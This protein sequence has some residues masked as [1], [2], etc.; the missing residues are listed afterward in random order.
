[1]ALIDGKKIAQE[2]LET[3]QQRV[4]A[5]SFVP[6]F[7]DVVVGNDPVVLSYVK[8]KGK[9]AERV[10][11]EFMEVQLQDTVSEE[12]LLLKI[13]EIQKT[14]RLCGVIVQ[15]PL[16]SH[17]S[18]KNVLDSIDPLLDVDCLGSK[19]MEKFYGSQ[20]VHIPPTA[21][22]IMEVLNSTNVSLGNSHVVIVGKGELV[23]K[24]VAYMLSSVS[25]FVVSV[26]Q[27]TEHKEHIIKDS[28]VVISAAGSPGI[29]RGEH[30]QEG[31][32]VVDAGTSED[33]GGI[34]GDVDTESVLEQSSY[35]AA[36]PGGV[37]PVTIAKL[38]V[39]VVSVAEQKNK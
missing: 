24:P 11:I 28:N 2:I 32:V 38:L 19:N 15:L 1:M 25:P 30:I 3:V 29:I 37:G 7:C 14:E 12:V 16:P 18:R 17:I 34:V 4:K 22:A 31:A 26:D 27:S 23:G 6:I 20:S 10:G 35:L 39:N 8:A 5:L 36:V 13:Q 9:A 33:M 21:A